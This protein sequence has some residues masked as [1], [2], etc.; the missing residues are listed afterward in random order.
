MSFC[1]LPLQE[2]LKD[3]GEISFRELSEILEAFQVSSGQN[4]AIGSTTILLNYLK[5]GNAFVVG[6]Y[7]YSGENKNI[8]SVKDLLALYKEI[9]LCV[10]LTIDKDLKHYFF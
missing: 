2:Q 1:L 4:F 8:S 5:S 9:D 6:N 10:D 3:I 7:N